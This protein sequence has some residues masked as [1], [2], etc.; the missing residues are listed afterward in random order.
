MYESFYGFKEKPFNLTPDPDYFYM[1]QTHENAYTH[2][3]YAIAENKGFAVITGEIGSGKTTLI[4]FLL[5]KIQQDIHVGVISKSSVSPVQFIKLLCEEFELNVQR[6]DKGG[7]LDAFSR[8][9]LKEFAERKRVVLIIDEAQHLSLETL[10]EIRML[11]NLED[12]KH[13]L[14]QIMLVGQPELAAKLQR[15]GLEQFAQFIHPE[16]FK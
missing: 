16:L 2:F 12:A 3:E 11:S 13:H 4:N 15:N 6:L 1:S 7:M 5:D 9:L 10:E 14:I 8:F